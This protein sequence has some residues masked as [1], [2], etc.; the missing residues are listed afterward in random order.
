VFIASLTE[1]GPLAATAKTMA[2]A[3]ARMRV[4]AENVAHMHTPGYRAKLLA[5]ASFQAALRKALELR[6]EAVG[7]P[8][9]IDNSR[10]FRTDGS[11]RLQVFPTEQPVQNILLHDGTNLSLERQMADLAETG[12]THELAASLLKG[13]L[14]RLR[15]AIRG[16]SG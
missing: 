15:T 3:E 5:P 4:I 10:E 7:K 16:R 2:F 1:R 9:V 14:D 8:L 6:G 13:G 11:G 12:M